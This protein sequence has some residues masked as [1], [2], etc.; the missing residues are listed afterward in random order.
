MIPALFAFAA[1]YMIGDSVVSMSK[2]SA[3]SDYAKELDN[4]AVA[5]VDK[6]NDRVNSTKKD[7]LVALDTLGKTKIALMSGNV[8]KIADAMT[9]VHNNFKL[10]NDTEGLRELREKGFQQSVLS[11]VTEYSNKALALMNAES[12][13]R[14]G[15]GRWSRYSSRL[16]YGESVLVSLCPFKS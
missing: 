4:E 7:M 16:H 6:V 2:A 13:L 1:G 9:K 14:H 15:I 3:Y 5:L 11:E 12:K 8:M 10:N